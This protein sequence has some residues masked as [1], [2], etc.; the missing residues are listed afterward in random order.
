MKLLL[1]W[2]KESPKRELLAI[3]VLSL[4]LVLPVYWITRREFYRADGDYEVYISMYTFVT[5]FVQSMHRLPLWNP[6]IGTGIPVLGDPISGILN[7]FTIAPLILFGV[8]LGMRFV[9]WEAILASGVAIWFALK[10]FK[11]S[12]VIK[13]WAS[14]LYMVS[15]A[16][17]SR[18]AAG[19]LEQMWSLAIIPIIGKFLLKAKLSK[20]EQVVAG[21]FLGLLVLSGD[22]YRT[23]Y[24]LLFFA[25]SRIYFFLKNDNLWYLVIE[26]VG[27][28][29]W[30]IV[31]CGVKLWFFARDVA[32]FLVRFF[33]IDAYAGSLHLWLVP[34]PFIIPFQ[35][36]FYDRPTIRRVL[37]L[38]YNW[39]E[40]YAFITPLPFLFFWYLRQMWRYAEVRISLII[41]I[42]SA[43]LSAV[44]F[45]YSPAYWLFHLLPMLQQFRASQRIFLVMVPFIMIIACF[46]A[47]VMWKKVQYRKRLVGAFIASILLCLAISMSTLRSAF[48]PVRVKEITIAQS[49]RQRDHGNYF[50]AT[51]VCCMQMALTTTKIPILNFY[52]GWLM[53][54]SPNFINAT[55]TG[56][57][58][59][60]LMTIKPRYVIAPIAEDLR[61]YDYAPFMSFGNIVVWKTDHETIRPDIHF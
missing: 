23:F 36:N 59:D 6:Y 41:L 54:Q 45:P 17:I 37:G 55:A 12:P 40:Y 27:V 51:A 2:T 4:L 42:G 46:G 25:I 47:E 21:V 38:A 30:F 26:S 57:D 50:V 49:L 43:F 60:R 19:H 16:G 48:E 44:K 53:R 15:G 32:P 33:P 20:K 61:M 22:F 34:L 52:Y 28:L 3:F 24:M 39:N 9:F 31:I 58:Y 10:D 35:V 29:T 14:L 7:P 11:I 8:P 1:N 56:F 18:I 5:Q 13:L